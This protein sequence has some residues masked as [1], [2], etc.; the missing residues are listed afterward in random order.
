MFKVFAPMQ[1]MHMHNATKTVQLP[2]PASHLQTSTLVM[3]LD[4]QAYIHVQWLRLQHVSA[5]SL[6]KT[7][8]TSH[9][10]GSAFYQLQTWEVLYRGRKCANESAHLRFSRRLPFVYSCR[11]FVGV[12]VYSKLQDLSDLVRKHRLARH[13]RSV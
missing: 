8:R 2:T 4:L 7:R 1:C 5:Y 10:L 3:C 12:H 11:L 13:V 6:R 9:Y